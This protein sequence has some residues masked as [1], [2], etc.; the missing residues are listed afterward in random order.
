MPYPGPLRVRSGPQGKFFPGPPRA[1][2]TTTVTPSNHRWEGTNP[3]MHKLGFSVGG[4]QLLLLLP[5]P[6]EHKSECFLAPGCAFPFRFPGLAACQRAASWPLPLFLFPSFPTSLP[7][8]ATSP[9]PVPHG[10][11]PPCNAPWSCPPPSPST[12]S[13]REASLW[14]SSY[15]CHCLVGAR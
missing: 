2:A 3:A 9:L 12:Y 5:W 6:A 13:G 10:P 15:Q 4:A 11:L 14:A 8:S 7:N 1:S